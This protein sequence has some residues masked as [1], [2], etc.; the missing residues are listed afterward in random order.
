MQGLW[1]ACCHQSLQLVPKVLQTTALLASCSAVHLAVMQCP[2]QPSV[3]PCPNKK[4]VLIAGCLEAIGR[5]LK[6]GT[7]LAELSAALY[8]HC[9]GWSGLVISV[10]LLL[11]QVCPLLCCSSFF[12][13][14][15]LHSMLALQMCEHS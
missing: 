7:S 1:S 12:F 4:H 5:C 15:F 8:L 11:E 13:D 3:Q 6:A 14:D 2:Q 10:L 9:H